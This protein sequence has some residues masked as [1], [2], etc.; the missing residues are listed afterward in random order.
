MCDLQLGAGG[1]GYAIS[2]LKKRGNNQPTPFDRKLAGY[3]AQHLDPSNVLARRGRDAEWGKFILEL[4]IRWRDLGLWLEV[5][6]KCGAEQNLTL[7]GQK[8]LSDAW[9]TFGFEALQSL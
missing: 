3:V 9:D 4:A 1:N 2:Q 5:A 8:I 6:V 7:L